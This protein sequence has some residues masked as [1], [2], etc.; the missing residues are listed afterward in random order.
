MSGNAKC[1]YEP[2]NKGRL[3]G[4]AEELLCKCVGGGNARR[5]LQ[6]VGVDAALQNAAL[7]SGRLSR[8]ISGSVY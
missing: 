5:A 8:G 2:S 3:D 4:G 6:T 7:E 1:V